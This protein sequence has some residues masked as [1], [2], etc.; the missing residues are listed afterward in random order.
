MPGPG[1][2]G[3]PGPS[4]APRAVSPATAS[5]SAAGYFAIPRAHVSDRD[6]VAIAQ[7]RLA[8]PLAVDEHAVEAAIVEDHR[9]P[10]PV[11][12][13][14]MPAGD[15]SVVEHDVGSGAAT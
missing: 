12:D 11:D 2:L 5:R 7:H 14:G 8:D 3:K 10:A 1:S 4:R 15:G 9:P 6:A 13:D